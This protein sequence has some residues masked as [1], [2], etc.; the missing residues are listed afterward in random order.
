MAVGGSNENTGDAGAG[1]VQPLPSRLSGTFDGSRP[2]QPLFDRRASYLQS[3]ATCQAGS[4]WFGALNL[5]PK[6]ALGKLEL[7]VRKDAI[8]LYASDGSFRVLPLADRNAYYATLIELLSSKC[9]VKNVPEWVATHLKRSYPVKK[10]QEEYLIPT[11][12]LRLLPGGRLRTIRNLVHKSRRE[13]QVRLFSPADLAE[14]ERVNA[15]WYRQ[16]KDLKF[17]T[18]DKTSIDWLL[19]NHAMLAVYLPETAWAGVWLG[20]RLLSFTMA[21]MLHEGVWSAYTERFDRDAPIDG[22]N[23][24]TWSDLAGLYANRGVP[25]ENDGTADTTALRHN[26]GKLNPTKVSFYEVDAR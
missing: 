10:Q 19:A 26:K 7:E 14:Y 21:D 13:A 6:V 23:W 18:Y 11:E 2:L 8:L 9:Y 4:F 22:S 25:F 24:R 5:L 17:R 12:T 16:N 20:D 1:V 15:L 3:L